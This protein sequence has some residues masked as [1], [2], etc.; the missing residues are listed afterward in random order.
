MIET[1][2]VDECVKCACW[3][4][5][6]LELA[7]QLEREIKEARIA[8]IIKR[9][10]CVYCDDIILVDD[11]ADLKQAFLKH[12]H[13]CNKH[14]MRQL[15]EDARYLRDERDAATRKLAETRQFIAADKLLAHTYFGRPI[16][17]HDAIVILAKQRDEARVALLEAI[18]AAETSE[19][20][21]LME[22]TLK[23]WRKAAVAGEDARCPTCRQRNS[24]AGEREMDD[25]SVI[26]WYCPVVGCANHA[27][28]PNTQAQGRPPLG[29]DV[30]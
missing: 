25:G 4:A 24:R 21:W 23:R 11:H 12:A 5:P 17:T 18:D 30:P 8:A 2:R 29:E 1:P 9:L 13:E 15:E 3:A 10:Q 7:R 27:D 22:Y 26:V 19:Q 14:P 6:L 28:H 16:L 20:A